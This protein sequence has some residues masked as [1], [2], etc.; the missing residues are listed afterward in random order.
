MNILFVT[1]LRINEIADRGVYPDLMRKF[2]RADIMYT[3]LLHWNAGVIKEQ[4]WNKMIMYQ[5]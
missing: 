3:L 1:I 5:S 2:R 4:P